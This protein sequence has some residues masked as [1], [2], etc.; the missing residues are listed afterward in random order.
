MKSLNFIYSYIDI[1]SMY[2][3]PQHERRGWMW[4]VWTCLWL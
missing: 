3:T 2:Y 1:K 4:F